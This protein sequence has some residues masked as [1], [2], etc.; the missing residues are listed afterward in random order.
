MQFLEKDR[1]YIAAACAS[2]A[3][4]ASPFKSERTGAL[5]SA[6]LKTLANHVRGTGLEMAF[7]SISEELDEDR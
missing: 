1:A 6:K 3:M 2:L 4:Q 5:V 7:N